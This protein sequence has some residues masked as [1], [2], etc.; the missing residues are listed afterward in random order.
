MRA[1]FGRHRRARRRKGSGVRRA[2]WGRRG[3]RWR[4]AVCLLTAVSAACGGG[5]ASAPSG[6]TGLGGSFEETWPASPGR[7]DQVLEVL[8]LSQAMR[9]IERTNLQFEFDK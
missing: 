7:P 1:R 8:G 2:R 9:R 3:G 4:L 6:P 5:M